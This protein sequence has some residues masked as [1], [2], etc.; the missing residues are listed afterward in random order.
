[1]TAQVIPFRPMTTQLEN[2]PNRIRE[3]RKA[4][5]LTQQALGDRVGISAVHVGHL[6]LGR[7]DISL[8]Q[9]RSLARELGVETVDLLGSDDNPLA[10]SP[11]SRRLVEH[12]DAADEPGRQAIE[13]VA[14]SF[15][16]YKDAAAVDT[17]QDTDHPARTD[18]RQA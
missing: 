8:S 13:R 3:L 9:L 14:E 12:W 7:R 5:R 18:K 10:N 4:R 2:Y 1:M 17:Q 6:E 15:V 11:R 16:P